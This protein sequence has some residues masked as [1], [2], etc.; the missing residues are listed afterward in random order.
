ML[1]A[2]RSIAFGG[3]MLKFGA[4]VEEA[5]EEADVESRRPTAARAN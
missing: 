2:A 4:A 3:T 5:I 1:S